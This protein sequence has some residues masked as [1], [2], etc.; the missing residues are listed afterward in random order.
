MR[1]IKFVLFA[2]KVVLQLF[3]L[4]FKFPLFVENVLVL[5][6]QSLKFGLQV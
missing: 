4:R 5:R 2:L 6:L 1:Q 3:D